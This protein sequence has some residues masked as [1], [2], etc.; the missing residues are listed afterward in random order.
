MSKYPLEKSTLK[1]AIIVELNKRSIRYREDSLDNFL[2]MKIHVARSGNLGMK[3]LESPKV[4]ITKDT[5]FRWI[6]A[7]I[8]K[9]SS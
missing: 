7:F 8:R 2:D 6:D 1:S 9:W 4:D 3:K 5:L